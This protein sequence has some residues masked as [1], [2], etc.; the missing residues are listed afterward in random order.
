MTGISL[1]ETE[2]ETL[3]DKEEKETSEEEDTESE[4]VIRNEKPVPEIPKNDAEKIQ[5][6][7]NTE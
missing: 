1:P 6:K 5:T 2:A 7:E 3:L 4:A